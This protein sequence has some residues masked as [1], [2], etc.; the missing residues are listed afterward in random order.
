MQ[1]QFHCPTKLRVGRGKLARLAESVGAL[2]QR[3]LVVIDPGVRSASAPARGACAELTRTGLAC[4]IFE[5]IPSNPSIATVAAGAEVFRQHRADVVVAIGGGSAL[6]SAKAIAAV[7]EHG[8]SIWD[9]IGDDLLPGPI[10]PIVAVPTTA[11]T[12]S[13][14]TPWL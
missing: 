13:E 1:F 8:G 7:A 3:P 2:G 11:G 9:Y 6:D 4:H 12:G 14:T 10:A 5:E